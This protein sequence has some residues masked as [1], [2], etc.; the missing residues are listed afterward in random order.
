[1]EDIDIALL[2][3]KSL[4]GIIALTSRTFILQLIAFGATVLLTIFLSPT[5]FGIYFVVSAIISFLGY[6]SDIGL[7][8]ALIQKKEELMREDLTTTFTIQQIL[9]GLIVLIALLTSQQIGIFYRLD[10]DGVWL[11]RALVFSFFLSSLKT[12]PSILLERNLEFHKLVIP[13]L[14][15]TIGFYGI[16]VTLAWLGFGIQSFTWAVIARGVI[17]LL[18]M[19]IISPWRIG[20]GFSLPV[21]KRLLRFGLPFQANSF[22]ALVKDDL[23]T[24]FLG[25]ILPLYQVGYIGWAKKYAEIPLRLIMDSVVRVTFPAFSRIQHDR[26]VLRNALEKT[27]FGLS[28]SIFPITVGLLFYVTPLIHI[29]PK[30]GKWEPAIV[31][32]YLFAVASAVSSLSTPLT[33][34]LNAVGRIKTT[35]GLMI[36][37]T[38]LTWSLTVLLIHYFGFN[39]FALALFI[40]SATLFIVIQLVKRI[41]AFSFFSNVRGALLAALCQGIF[42][43]VFLG[44]FHSATVTMLIFSG[45]CGVILYIGVLWSIEKERIR[46]LMSQMRPLMLWKR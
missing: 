16:A 17:G 22:L 37:W 31:S 1:M 15:E 3:K 24:I 8:A 30:Y 34:A 27:L 40:I 7:A 36:M 43:S 21:A 29:I 25:K 35:L 26:T 41:T 45:I 9:V 12:I 44:V 13:Q 46:L 19:Y 4:T 11:F 2:K 5:V 23:M 38:V 33:N 18:S 20:I 6:F 39:G 32:F 28:V 14:L 42:Y 10:M